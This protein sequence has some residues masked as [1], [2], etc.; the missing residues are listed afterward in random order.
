MLGVS[1]TTLHRWDKE[2]ILSAVRT[3][4]GHRR[5]LASDFATYNPLGLNTAPLSR[6]TIAYAW[7]SRHD[8]KK[9]L[10]RQVKVLD[11]YCV[12]HGWQ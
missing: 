4:T 5:Y 7:V 2:G 6:P 12:S 10:V 3:S 8:Q 1:V 9:D 11:L